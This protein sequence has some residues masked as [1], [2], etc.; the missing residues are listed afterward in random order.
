MKLY[1]TLLLSLFITAQGFS[2]QLSG[3]VI[4]AET[5]QMNFESRHYYL[6]IGQDRRN[7]NPDLIENPGY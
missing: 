6:P 7:N 4:D 2:Q 5:N 1:I 3:K